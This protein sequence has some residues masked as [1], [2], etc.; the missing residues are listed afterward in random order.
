[1]IFVL[2]ALKTSKF[3][4]WIKPYK[5]AQLFSK[6]PDDPFSQYVQSDMEN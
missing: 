5:I 4:E 3:F 2:A 6:N 1:V